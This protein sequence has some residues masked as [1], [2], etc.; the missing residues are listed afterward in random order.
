MTQ[1]PVIPRALASQDVDQAI[2]YYLEQQAE[3][4]ALG[5]IDALEHAYR[6][7]GRYPESGSPRYAHELDLPGL[8]SW[9]VKGYPY[10]VFYVDST[11]HID[12]WRVL[13]GTRD[14]PAWF[15]SH[16]QR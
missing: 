14:I 16:G 8:R 6:Q 1:K 3:A 5:F 7:I 12:V 2:A 4:A 11:E 13:H 10:M 15:S 9:P